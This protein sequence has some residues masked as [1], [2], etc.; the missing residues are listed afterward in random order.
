LFR[1][2]GDIKGAER[3]P[4]ISMAGKNWRFWG[5]LYMKIFKEWS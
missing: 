2:K 5:A 3:P 1:R 4:K